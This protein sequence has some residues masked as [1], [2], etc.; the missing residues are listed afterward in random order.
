MNTDAKMSP[1]LPV[2][3]FWGMMIMQLPTQ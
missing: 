3:P 2:L 1:A